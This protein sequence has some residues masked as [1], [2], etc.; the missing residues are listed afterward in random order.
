MIKEKIIIDLNS[1]ML[2]EKLY[3]QFSYKVNRLLLDLFDSGIEIS[4]TI[5]G[6][7]AQIESFFKALRGEKRYMD[8]YINNGLSDSRTMMNKRDLERAVSNFERETGLRWPFK[9]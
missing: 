5:R 1:K 2:N 7:Q 4:P 3:T 9:N 8:S 6:T